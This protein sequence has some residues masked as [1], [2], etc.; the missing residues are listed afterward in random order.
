MLVVVGAVIADSRL[1]T[2]RLQ[3]LRDAVPG[4][5]FPWKPEVFV[6]RKSTE[7]F[8]PR[9]DRRVV[10]QCLCRLCIESGLPGV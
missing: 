8:C 3:N 4:A 1:W 5:Q 10:V 2:N 7:G 9:T 6:W